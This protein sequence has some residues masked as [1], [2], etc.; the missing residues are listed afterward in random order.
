MCRPTATMT[1]SQDFFEIAEL[2][3]MTLLNLNFTDLLRVYAGKKHCHE[4]KEYT[5]PISAIM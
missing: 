1:A 2:L 5:G 3:E 4:Q